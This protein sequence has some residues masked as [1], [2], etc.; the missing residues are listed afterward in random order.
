MFPL[1]RRDDLDLLLLSKGIA[2][3]KLMDERDSLLAIT[4]SL[5]HAL[6]I[7]HN[8][9]CNGQAG[10]SEKERVMASPIYTSWARFSCPRCKQ[11]SES[12]VVVPE[13]LWSADKN[14]DSR[15]EDTCSVQC[16]VCDAEFDGTAISTI[17]W[18]QID[19]NDHPET[20]VEA[21]PAV[22]GP[23]IDALLED[24]T[25]PDDPASIFMDS[26]HETMDLLAD[27]GKGGSSVFNRMIFVQQFGALEAYLSD[28]LRNA[29]EGRKGALQSLLA[30]DADLAKERFGLREIS[31]NPNLVETRVK[32]YLRS[33]MYHNLPKVGALYRIVFGFDIV[34]LLDADKDDLFKA[35]IHRHH[36]VHRN[37][38]DQAGVKLE[39]FTKEY[40]TKIADT[41]RKLVEKIEQ[42]RSDPM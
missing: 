39:F 17:S 30:N 21:S 16:S 26:Y 8:I 22:E 32:E 7:P 31:E 6:M 2:I 33:I 27:Y 10:E 35:I 18:C 4:C 38:F 11:V 20:Q 37:G 9:A 42:K 5:L 23:D 34:H 19:L 29:V 40:V 28:T 1:A 36:C 15:V 14:E 24:F 3:R 13:P 12:N 25:V 41:M